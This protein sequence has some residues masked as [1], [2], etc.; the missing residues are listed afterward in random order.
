[1]APKGTSLALSVCNAAEG[2]GRV[3]VDPP[4]PTRRHEM[5][6]SGESDEPPREDVVADAL[7][8]PALEDE[9]R[10][11]AR[12]KQRSKVGWANNHAP[13][14]EG[15]QLFSGLSRAGCLS[16]N[17]LSQNGYLFVFAMLLPCYCNAI[18]MLL[19]WR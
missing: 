1:M 15:A 5:H 10:L 9:G 4:P 19:P 3:E 6:E 14:H 16:Q 18:A 8:Q 7:G 13:R 2:D 11:V 17:G 12:S